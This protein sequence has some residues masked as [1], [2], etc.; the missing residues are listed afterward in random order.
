MIKFFSI[1][2]LCLTF[3][4]QVYSAQFKEKAKVDY[5]KFSG[6]KKEEVKEEAKMKACLN[7]LKKYSNSFDSQMYENYMKVKEEIENNYLDYMICEVIDDVQDKKAKTYSVVVSIEILE[8][9][10]NAIINQSSAI[11]DASSDEKS[12]IVFTFFARVVDEAKSF[13]VKEYERT[14]TSDSET[15]TEIA[16]TDGT[17]TVIDSEVTTS[18][19]K[20]TGGSDT[21]KSDQLVYS[22]R[23]DINN[24]FIDS[25]L[26]HFGDAKFDLTDIYDI[27]DEL[28]D[29]NEMM[30]EEFEFEGAF[31]RRTLS[32]VNKLLQEDGEIG[33]FLIATAS[34]GQKEIDQSTG[35]I[36]SKATISG[37]V[38][39]L[40][41]KR[42]KKIA[43]V[44]PQ[45]LA[46][47]GST[48]EESISIALS[49]SAEESAKQLINA[50]NNRGVK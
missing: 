35:N 40:T 26:D 9:P 4:M 19:S 46:G 48:Q 49:N 38:Y 44:S 8:N 39:D 28:G 17:E 6:S 30:L 14:D 32:K 42:A 10:L 29:Y 33:F 50:L 21:V 41:G 5:K 25:M 47:L 16:A 1:L 20:T 27:S 24:N 13:D 2:F 31:G 36:L 7:G 12:E 11:N 37:S 22:V 15:A 43:S 34:I 45:V 18:S 3:S 23:E